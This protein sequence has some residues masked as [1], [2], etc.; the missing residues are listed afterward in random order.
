MFSLPIEEVN[1]IAFIINDRDDWLLAV[2]AY[3]RYGI[4]LGVTNEP[5]S[6]FQSILIPIHPVISGAQCRGRLPILPV[7]QLACMEE[8][9][10]G[11]LIGT[12]GQSYFEIRTQ[13]QAR[14]SQVA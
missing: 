8:I 9:P 7:G 12:L 4:R 1:G 5:F 10:N 3:L 13:K 11:I 14:T 6:N 2:N